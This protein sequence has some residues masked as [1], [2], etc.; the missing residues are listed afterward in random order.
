MMTYTFGIEEIIKLLPNVFDQNTLSN[1]VFVEAM[2]ENEKEKKP[3]L[4]MG[5]NE[6][7][8]ALFYA[9]QDDPVLII[10]HEEHL[11]TSEWKVMKNKENVVFCLKNRLEKD[12]LKS[13]LKL[14]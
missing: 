13:I 12:L 11:H 14:Q 9:K 7:A 5:Q 2:S 1:I 3:F 4:E 10:G 8:T 6:M